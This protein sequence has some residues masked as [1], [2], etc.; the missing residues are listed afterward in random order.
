MCA[1]PDVRADHAKSQLD[2]G[3]PATGRLTPEEEHA[4]QRE[5]VKQIRAAKLKK[6]QEDVRV[7]LFV[8]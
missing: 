4:R 7:C 5:M 3:P 8:A 2:K 6:Q 1:P